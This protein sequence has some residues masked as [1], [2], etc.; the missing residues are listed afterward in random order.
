MTYFV[1]LTTTYWSSF[2]RLSVTSCRKQKSFSPCTFSQT[3]ALTMPRKWSVC[4]IRIWCTLGI[5]SLQVE[6]AVVWSHWNLFWRNH[7]GWLSLTMN[8][9]CGGSETYLTWSLYLPSTSI[10]KQTAAT[11]SSTAKALNFFKN[12]KVFELEGKRENGEDM[13]VLLTKL[14]ALHE[15]FFNGGYHDVTH[16]LPRVFE[17]KEYFL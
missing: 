7:V 6:T 9:D 3:I 5:E 8:L 16:V 12:N 4:L 13:A 17:S 14:K 2:D 11:R 1:F 15:L 10:S